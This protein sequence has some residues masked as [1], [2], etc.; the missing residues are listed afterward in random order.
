MAWVVK[1]VSLCGPMAVT[2]KG[3]AASRL[4]STNSTRCAAL[5]IERVFDL[6]LEVGQAF[7]AGQ[8]Q[9]LDALD[10]QRAERVVAAAGI[11]PAE[12]QDRRGQVTRADAARVAHAC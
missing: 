12:D 2:L 10:E 6:E 9:R 11:A 5:E 1:L 4:A 7:D 3:A 8:I